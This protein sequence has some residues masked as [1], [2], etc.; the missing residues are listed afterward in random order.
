MCLF[1][2]AMEQH[3]Y[4]PFIKAA[5][6]PVYVALAQYSDLIKSGDIGNFPEVYCRN[7]FRAPY[8]FYNLID[9]LPYRICLSYIELFVV[10]L[11]HLI[12]F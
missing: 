4:V 10:R 3:D 8:Q 12:F 9:L 2:E 6:D 7:A 11:E 1:L 5:E